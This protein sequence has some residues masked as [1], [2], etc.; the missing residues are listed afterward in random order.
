MTSISGLTLSSIASAPSPPVARTK[1]DRLVQHSTFKPNKRN[2][3]EKRDG[4]VALKLAE[5]EVRRREGSL[6][7]LM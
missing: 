3:Q 2:F 6:A 1:R 5:G 4:S 7:E